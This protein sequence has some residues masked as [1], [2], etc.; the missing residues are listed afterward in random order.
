MDL[1]EQIDD[2]EAQHNDQLQMEARLEALL[3]EME[4]SCMFDDEDMAL[5]RHACGMPKKYISP[6]KAMFD[7][8]TDVFGKGK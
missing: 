1:T 8:L 4:C 3:Y 2:Y 5:I 7:D 6:L